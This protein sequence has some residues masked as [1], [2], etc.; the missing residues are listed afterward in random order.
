MVG[1][2]HDPPSTPSSEVLS[3]DDAAALAGVHYM[4]VYR[5]V[6]TS[7]LPAVKQNGRWAV[8]KA[9]VLQVA[10]GGPEPAAGSARSEEPAAARVDR[11]VRQLTAGD[12]AGAEK[13]IEEALVG[14]MAPEDVHLDVLG[15]AIHLIGTQWAAGTISVAEEHRSTTVMLRLLGSQAHHFH[16]RGRRRGTI[17]LGAPAGDRHALPLALIVDPLR[18]RGFDVVDLGADVPTRQFATTAALLDG[19]HAVGVHLAVTADAVVR[20]L[21]EALHAEAPDARLVVGGAAVTDEAH[22]RRLGADAHA[23]SARAALE[24]L[25]APTER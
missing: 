7:R 1:M 23:T 21:T 22:A 12:Q 17:L 24:L 25:T 19:L 9:D 10:S 18:G 20:E 6:R 11:L 5:W 3:L 4:T 15:P 2:A 14:G 8:S 13:I 16:R